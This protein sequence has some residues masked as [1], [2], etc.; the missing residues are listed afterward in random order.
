MFQKEKLLSCEKLFHATLQKY[1]FMSFSKISAKCTIK[2]KDGKTKTAEVNRSILSALNSY[3]IKSAVALDFR[4]L[5][6]YPLCPVPLSICNGDGTRRRTNK[7]KL[8]ESLLIGVGSLD[9]SVLTSFPKDVLLV[10]LIALINTVV[11]ELPST[12]EEFAQ[13]LMQRILKNYKRVD[14]LV[15]NYKN[16]ANSLKLN[17]QTMGGQSEKIQIA[18]LQ[19]RIPTE[20]RTRIL[21]NNENKGRLIELIPKYIKKQKDECLNLLKSDTIVFSTDDKYFL[22]TFAG[23]SNITELEMSHEEVDTKIILHAMHLR[24]TQNVNVTIFPP[25][26]DID[27]IVLLLAFLQDHKENIDGHGK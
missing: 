10:H 22:L 26:G 16:K 9:K 6:Q 11:F 23:I 15:E 8:K 7:S 25:S 18:S 5:L 1:N 3:S 12:Y 24:Q 17:E 2:S 14:L 13:K 19:T 21:V 20:F 27:I 4:Q